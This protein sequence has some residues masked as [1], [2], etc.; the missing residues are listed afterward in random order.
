MYEPLDLPLARAAVDRDYVS[1]DNPD[2]FDV[3]WENPATR[4]IALHR[5]KVL[6]KGD[7]NSPLA[8]LALYPVEQVPSA[9]LRAYLGVTTQSSDDE[10]AG[11]PVVLAVLSQNAADQLEPDPSNWH[12]LRRSGAG[13]SARDAGIYSQALALAN[14]HESHV[15]C[16]RCGTP[17]VIQQGGW[18][19][20]CF[21][22]DTQTFPRT[23]PAVIVA[24]TDEQDR[25]LMGSQGVWEDNRWSILAGFVEAGESLGAAVVREVF[26][27]AG[28]RVSTPTYRGSQPWPFP[29][30]LMMGFTAKL[31]PSVGHQEL[32]PDGEEI[33]KLRWFSRE[34]LAAEAHGLLLPGPLSIARALIDDWFGG[35]LS[36]LHS[37]KD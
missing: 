9:Q 36:L 37:P 14:F 17:T 19:R 27:E 22:D 15:Y 23:D 8:A 30:S 25:L 29:C 21:N 24:V 3:L 18:S 33:A 28:V 32:V 34:E 5:G 7:P 20:R 6:L 11:T 35:D 26:E 31:D 1:R 4:V 16:S 10:P 12:H 13:L 2:L